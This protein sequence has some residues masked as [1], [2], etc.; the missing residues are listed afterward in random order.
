[1]P[2]GIDDELFEAEAGAGRQQ[3]VVAMGRLDPKKGVDLLIR[4]FQ[5]VATDSAFA[6]WRLVLAGDG[7]TGYVESLRQLAATGPARERIEFRG[8]IQPS[9]RRPLL[10]MSRLFV[11][12]SQQE[13]FGIAVVEALACGVPALVSPGVNLADDIMAADA[14]WVT[15]RDVDSLTAALRSALGNEAALE[16]CGAQARRFAARFRWPAAAQAL[17]AMYADVVGTWKIEAPA[18]LQSMRSA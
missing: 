2:L 4:A 15:A 3:V 16:R 14:G 18:R 1:V 12:P 17:T 10:S 6:R 9:E 7:E 13:N 5:R 11:L 8:W